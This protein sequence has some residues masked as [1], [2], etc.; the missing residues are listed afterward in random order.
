MECQEKE[1]IDKWN[2]LTCNGCNDIKEDLTHCE[3]PNCHS[4]YLNYEDGY[5]CKDCHLNVCEDCS[6]DE[7]TTFVYG[8]DFFCKECL[9]IR[10]NNGKIDY[11]QNYRKECE[12]FVY[13][14]KGEAVYLCITCD[15]SFC[16]E[17]RYDE[18][19]NFYC[20]K[21]ISKYENDTIYNV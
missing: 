19:P 12:N 18:L 7:F 9:K 20:K 17:C 21:C 2:E 11:C 15:R 1:C 4:M 6:T 8:D 10:V 3:M 16:S 14:T 5:N 13:I